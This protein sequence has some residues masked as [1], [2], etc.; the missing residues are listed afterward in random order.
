M[1][2][3]LASAVTG[4]LPAFARPPL[5]PVGRLAAFLRSLTAW[6][7]P[8]TELVDGATA[9]IGRA[10]LPKPCKLRAP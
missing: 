8:W 2:A 5:A 7:E 9:V 6:T 4:R 1:I 10:T 3:R